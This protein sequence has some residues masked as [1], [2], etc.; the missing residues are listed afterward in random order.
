[1]AMERVKGKN[2]DGIS[3]RKQKY[4]ESFYSDVDK[5]NSNFTPFWIGVIVILLIIF[6]L[7]VSFGVTIKRNISTSEKI[8]DGE[9]LNLASFAERMD[10]LRGDGHKILIFNQEEFATAAGLP[11]DDFPLANAR[12]EINKEKLRLV[13]RIKGSLAF[14]PI[15]INITHLVI[16]GKFKF[17]VAPDSF[18]N[19]ILPSDDKNKIEEIFER[20]FNAVLEDNQS[21]AEE[22]ILSDES[23]ELHLIKEE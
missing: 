10:N 17:L 20:N 7:L 8:A 12:F 2:L 16:D 13:G 3:R 5:S 21:K 11:E 19:I 1:M 6:G 9:S 22:I 15:G 18:E 23:I 14:W 4:T